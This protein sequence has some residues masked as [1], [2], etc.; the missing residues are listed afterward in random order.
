MVQFY[1]PFI[2]Y[3]IGSQTSN[4]GL[5]LATVCVFARS[6]F[7]AAELSGG[8]TGHLANNEVSFMIL[9]GA[10][11]MIACGSFTLLHPGYCFTKAGWAA[12]TYSFFNK[13]EEKLARD[14]ERT[15]RREARQ[16]AILDANEKRFNK[17]P[18]MVPTAAMKSSE[19]VTQGSDVSIEGNKEM[20]QT[21]GDIKEAP[22]A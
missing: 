15:E 12:A 7:R 6:V 13:S 17:G 14:Q 19:N 20:S 2:V 4:I 3:N 16:Q 21:A 11:I 8:F 1:F 18:K 5:T 10:M 22:H 9:D